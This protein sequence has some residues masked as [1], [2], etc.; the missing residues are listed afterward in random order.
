MRIEFCI[1]RTRCSETKSKNIFGIARAHTVNEIINQQS[2]VW[3][4]QENKENVLTKFSMAVR[5]YSPVA[6]RT[7]HRTYVI[8]IYVTKSER[9]LSYI[10]LLDLYLNRVR[11]VGPAVQSVC[12]IFLCLAT[13]SPSAFYISP[14]RSFSLILAHSSS[15]SLILAHFCS[16]ST[17][18][19]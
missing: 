10:Y 6:T 4:K 1:R 5:A 15:F 18:V 2:I 13:L 9:S 12:S 8:C 17:P 14:S 11:S 16:F 3:P 19:Q 7:L